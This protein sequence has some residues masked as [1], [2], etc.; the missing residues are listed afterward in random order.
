MRYRK[1]PGGKPVH[2]HGNHALELA[3]TFIPGCILF[4]LAVMQTGV[5]SENKYKSEMPDAE[6]KETVVVQVIG[7]QFEWHFRYPG[8][9][10]TFGTADDITSSGALH[11][12]V[13]RDVIVRLQTLDVLHSFW[14]PN[15]RLKQDLVPGMTIP[16]W[17]KVLPG[18]NN[19]NLGKYEIVCAELCGSGHTKMRGQL[20]V[21]TEEEFA[22]WKAKQFEAMGEHL[23]EKDP[24]WKYWYQPVQEASK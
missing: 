12:P 24:N 19:E 3:W 18:E 17:F 10:N 23:P 2:T 22:A 15:L 7:K 8:S 13:N 1:K 5:W 14:L 20:F 9:D 11:V 16:Q 6:A 21:D 4:V